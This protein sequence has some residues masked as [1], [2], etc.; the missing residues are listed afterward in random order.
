MPG[1]SDNPNFVSILGRAFQIMDCILESTEPIGVSQ[2]SK[3]TE[4]P[5]ANTFRILKTLEE[6]DAITEIGDG[7]VLSTQLIKYGNGA[8]RHNKFLPVVVPYLE[9]LADEVGETVN[10]GIQY[11]GSVL[12]IHSEDGGANTSLVS[13]LSPIMPMYCSSIGK[14]LL[15]HKDDAEI[16]QYFETTECLKRTVRTL[17]TKEEF[18]AE[19]NEILKEGISYDREEYDYGLSCFSM[20]VRNMRGQI[21]AGLSVSGPTSRLSYKGI[22]KL[23]QILRVAVNEINEVIRDREIDL[24]EIE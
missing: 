22:E 11:Q 3:L 12:V 10:L 17:T 9:K 24:P 18:L 21:I 14:L 1:K 6:L 15:S 19:R 7:Y 2:I 8:K 4:I 20:P 5:K 13:S 23:Q 16:D